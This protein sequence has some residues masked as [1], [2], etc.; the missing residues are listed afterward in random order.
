ML[1]I[2]HLPRRISWRLGDQGF[3]GLS[4]HIPQP[5]MVVTDGTF[6]HRRIYMRDPPRE[7][8]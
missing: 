5:Q 8:Q 4:P 3:R 2:T 6:P 1:E 7:T